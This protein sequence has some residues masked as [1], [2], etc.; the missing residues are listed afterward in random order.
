MKIFLQ[1]KKNIIEQNLIFLK[2]K[3]FMLVTQKVKKVIY[4]FF[5]YNCGFCKKVFSDL[6]ELISEDNEIEVVFIELPVLGQSSLL[7]SKA[8]YMAHKKWKIF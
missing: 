1:F 3:N 8:A 4:E 7:A 6:M 2:N 5:D